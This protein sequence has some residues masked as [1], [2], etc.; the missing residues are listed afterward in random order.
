MHV[1][2]TVASLELALQKASLPTYGSKRSAPA[3]KG[4]S[5]RKTIAQATLGFVGRR[6][7]TPVLSQTTKQLP[8]LTKVCFAACWQGGRRKGHIGCAFC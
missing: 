4:V 2:P 1:H 6:S 5:H 8:L 3:T 7:K